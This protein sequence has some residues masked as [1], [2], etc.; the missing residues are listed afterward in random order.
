MIVVVL[1][2][3]LM[4][5]IASC[6]HTV[7]LADTVASTRT[8][9]HG[10]SA[11]CRAACICFESSFLLSAQRLFQSVVPLVFQLC[12]YGTVSK[13]VHRDVPAWASRKRRFWCGSVDKL[14]ACPVKQFHASLAVSRKRLDI[15]LSIRERQPLPPTVP[16][17]RTS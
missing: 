3:R 9:E 2:A 15:Q 12:W 14:I 4:K 6:S 8:C 13:P 1:R 7:K 5:Q 16:P 17:Y 10:R 11:P